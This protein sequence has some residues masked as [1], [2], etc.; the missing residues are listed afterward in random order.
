MP[1]DAPDTA[2]M[3]DLN[4]QATIVLWP[5]AAPGSTFTPSPIMDALGGTSTEL[6]NL[7]AQHNAKPL[8]KEE[9]QQN[10]R[11]KSKPG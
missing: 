11:R 1:P 3:R 2:R 7:R 5:K 10:Q 6:N 9:K 8:V 4:G